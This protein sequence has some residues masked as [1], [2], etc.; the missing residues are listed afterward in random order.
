MSRRTFSDE[1]IA[2]AL[3]QAEQTS[4]GETVLLRKYPNSF[5]IR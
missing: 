2:M 3:Q 5:R 4:V 1:Q